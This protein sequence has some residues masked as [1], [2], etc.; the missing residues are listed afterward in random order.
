MPENP[1]TDVELRTV[2]IRDIAY[3]ALK[4]AILS[5]KLPPGQRLLEEQL[6][7]QLNISRTPLREA[8][9][10]LER[11]GFVVRLP[12]GGVQVPLLSTAELRNL[13]AIRRELEGLA[14]REAARS[15]DTAGCDEAREANDEMLDNWQK[16][17]M[18]EAY[19][20]GRAFHRA[21]YNTS[22]NPKLSEVLTNLL[23]QIA[24]YRYISVVHR[25][26]EAHSDHAALLEAIRAGDGEGACVLARDHV[27]AE[28]E[29]VLSR[30]QADGVE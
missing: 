26:Q 23:E 8:L 13:Y 19:E 17:R 10:A 5:H 29:L 6:T 24:R 16:G 12:A 4:K 11:E 9:Q 20:S 22:G 7:R 27:K 25:M 15:G 14:A 18:D 3:Q 21:I 1:F 28:C 30:L 2:A